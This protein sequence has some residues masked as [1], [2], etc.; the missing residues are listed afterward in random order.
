MEQGRDV[1]VVG[2]GD[3]AM[4]EALFLTRMCTAVYLIHRRD[5]FRASK[6]M[7]ERVIENKK[8]KLVLNSHVEEVLGDGK[9]VNAVCVKNEQTGAEHV[10]PLAALFLAIG[11][12]P[13][14][15]FTKGV[16]QQDENGYLLTKVGGTH[17]NVNGVFACGDVVDHTYRQAITAAGTGCA[18]A[19]DAERW[20]ELNSQ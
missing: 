12:I 15:D 7:I 18:A 6:V 10:I 4:E 3:S 9:V 2:G 20:L 19:I 5:K 8:I 14:S 1:C 13:N 17:T 11:H 16:V